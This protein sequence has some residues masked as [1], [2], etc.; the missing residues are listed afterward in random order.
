[1]QAIKMTEVTHLTQVLSKNIIDVI[2]K[3]AA[4]LHIGYMLGSLTA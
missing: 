2:G 4:S 1:M 3:Q